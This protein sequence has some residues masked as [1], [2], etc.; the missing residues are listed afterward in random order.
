M[1]SYGILF[2]SFNCIDIYEIYVN[3]KFYTLRYC[4]PTLLFEIL[5]NHGM[6]IRIAFITAIT[7]LP[8]VYHSFPLFDR[9]EYP[10]FH[11]HKS[12][13][14][15]LIQSHATGD[16]DPGGVHCSINFLYLRHWRNKRPKK[17]GRYCPFIG[18]QATIRSPMVSTDVSRR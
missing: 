15:F 2:R 3:L 7:V 8:P 10:F 12:V 9:L 6:P 11:H 16:Q 1:F 5:K 17:G 18:P 4:I 14:Y 13:I